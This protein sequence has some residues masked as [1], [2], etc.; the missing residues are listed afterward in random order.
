MGLPQVGTFSLATRTTMAKPVELTFGQA[1]LQDI[2]P[3]DIYQPGMVM[4]KKGIKEILSQVAQRY[5]DR[6]ADIDYKLM[7]L[8]LRT[9]E[10]TGGASFGIKDLRP[11]ESARKRNLDIQMRIKQVLDTT[12]DPKARR[13]AIVDILSN[14][15]EPHRAAV[16]KESQDEGNAFALQLKGAGRGNPVSLTTIRGGDLMVADASGNPV[17]LPLTRSYS[18][19]LTPAQY[20]AASFGARKGITTTKLSVASSGFLSKVLT[21]AAHRAVVVDEDDDAPRG[22]MRG[23]LVDTDDDDNVGALLAHPVAGYDRNTVLT[24]KILAA[25]KA[26]GNDEILVR[27]PIA[28]SHSASGVYAKDLGMREYGRLPQIGEAIGIVA[29]NAIGEQVTQA[30]LGAKHGSGRIGKGQVTPGLAGFSLVDKLVNPTAEQRGMAAHAQLDGRVNKIREAPQGGLFLTIGDQEHYISPSFTPQVKVG[31]VVEAGDV[32]TDGI[33]NPAE[34]TKFKGVGEGRAYFVRSLHRGLKEA[35]FPVDRRNIEVL[36]SGLIDRVRTTDEFGEYLPDSVVPY[37]Q[38]ERTYQPR[39][40]SRRLSSREWANRYLEEPVLHYTIGTRVTPSVAKTLSR[41]G[42]HDVLANDKPPPFE[43]EVVRGQDV[44]QTDPDWMTRFLGSHLTKGFTDAV[45]TGAVS[46]T[47]STSFVPS[48]AEVKDF[49]RTPLQMG[50]P[51]KD[52]NNFTLVPK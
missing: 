21:Q 4:D 22:Q 39:E 8:G 6:Y 37:S 33:A 49:G 45:H 34:V 18:Q 28:A 31:D 26:K 36:A 12:K 25:I 15:I 44:L 27:S 9:G 10:S 19:G 16:L 2:L 29:S 42:I 30:S 52:T 51:L 14:E 3:A 43:P 47:H 41:V 50:Q 24:P 5:P 7:R 23:F 48:R 17:P 13:A 46:D 35:G 38:L 40:D 32:L 20:F 1:M 11:A